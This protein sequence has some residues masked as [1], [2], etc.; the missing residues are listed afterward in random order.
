[1]LRHLVPSHSPSNKILYANLF[2]SISSICE[3]TF[4]SNDMLRQATFTTLHTQ[5]EI[6]SV[7]I[8]VLGS[9]SN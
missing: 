3:C 6:N 1:M 7:T 4:P 9:K 5:R 8:K 2:V